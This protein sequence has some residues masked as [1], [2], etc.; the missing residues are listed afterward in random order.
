[1]ICLRL[2]ME[3]HHLAL[4]SHP[5]PPAYLLWKSNYPAICCGPLDTL[6]GGSGRNARLYHVFPCVRSILAAGT[7]RLGTQLLMP[8]MK[9]AKQG[10]M[11]ST[12]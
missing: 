11:P 9:Q 10:S 4:S 12:I 8:E 6:S 3:F 5:Y 2:F 7:P 1:M